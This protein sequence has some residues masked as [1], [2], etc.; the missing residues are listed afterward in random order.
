MVDYLSLLKDMSEEMKEAA[1]EIYEA[2]SGKVA[3]K[4]LGHRA[5]LA[6][7]KAAMDFLI[8]DHLDFEVITEEGFEGYDGGGRPYLIVDPIDGTSNFSRGIPFSSIS[9]AMAWEDSMDSVFV[10]M[11]RDLFRDDLF[12][13]YRGKGSYLNGGR[14]RPRQTRSTLEAHFSININRAFPGKSR[15]LNVLPYVPYARH[16]GSAA[17]EGCYVASGRIDAYIDLRG[18]LR[19]FDVA[20]SQLI[21]K[22]AGGKLIIWQDGSR[23]VVLSKIGGISI[24][25]AATP[26]LMERITDLTG[27]Y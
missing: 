25:A 2:Y 4:E 14:I 19:V 16:L 21:V 8:R 23:E 13:G 3:P 11:V 17:L 1:L 27:S 12:W 9:L 10:G 22:E 7:A 5:D 18:V 15:S 6:S 26:Y 24:I 20:A